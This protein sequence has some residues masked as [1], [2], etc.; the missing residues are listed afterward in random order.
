MSLPITFGPYIK[1][2]PLTVDG[3][4]IYQQ[5]HLIITLVIFFK[6]KYTMG[7]V[8]NFNKTNI[9]GYLLYIHVACIVTVLKINIKEFRYPSN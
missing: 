6:G 8:I 4:S 2:S 1:G 5:N 3:L 9:P 7:S